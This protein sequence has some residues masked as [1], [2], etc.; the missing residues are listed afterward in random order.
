MIIMNNIE[1][2]LLTAWHNIESF[3]TGSLRLGIEHP[4]E[5]HVSYETPVN[6]AL[7]IISNIAI[8]SIASSKSIHTT[9]RKRDDG[10]YYISFQLLDK[11]QESVF[12]SMCSDLIDFSSGALSEKEAIKKVEIRYKQRRKLMEHQREAVLSEEK[13]KG[14]IGELLYL[15]EI[16]L[17]GKKISEALDGWVGPEGKDQDFVYDGIWREVKTTGIASVQITINSL[18]QLG[19]TDKGI[20][21][22]SRVDSCAPEKTDSFTL[23]S[24]VSDINFLFN[25]DVV[26]SDIFLDKLCSVGYI[27]MEEYDKYHY[28]FSKSDKYEVDEQFPRIKREDVRNEIL[29]CKYSLSISSIDNWRRE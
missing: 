5:W 8:D 15:K 3:K 1:N 23:R 25:E 4:L 26:Y 24:L 7:I 28:S 29:N 13:R 9:C 22:I 2:N 11:N 12:I 16:I 19:N 10:S 17:G 20:L 14:L 27:D 21:I 18:E 6:K